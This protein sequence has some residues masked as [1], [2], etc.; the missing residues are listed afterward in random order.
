MKTTENGWLAGLTAAVSVLLLISVSINMQLASRIRTMR[1]SLEQAYAKTGLAGGEALPPLEAKDLEGR[2]V[3]V[4]FDPRK[5]T[6]VY[7][8]TPQCGWCTRNL[9][10]LR[11]VAGQAQGRYLVVGLSL[12]SQ[13]LAEYVT[14]EALNFPVYHQPP[15]KVIASYKL[16]STPSTIVISPEGKV[17]RSWTGAYSGEVQKQVEELLH[18]SLP[19]LR[20]APVSRL[21]DARER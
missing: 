20:D 16:R 17:L 6:L 12:E 8:F 9:D 21:A 10:N 1:S 19:G 18:V 7:V 15:E 3:Q 11:A 4:G 14:R 5:P 2:D 13:S